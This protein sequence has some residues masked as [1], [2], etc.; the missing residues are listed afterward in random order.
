MTNDTS[1]RQGE[2]ALLADFL[3][4]LIS[5]FL[6]ACSGF[7]MLVLQTIELVNIAIRKQLFLFL[8]HL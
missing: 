2:I 7:V 4:K 5:L 1:S 3:F 8:Y 6:T